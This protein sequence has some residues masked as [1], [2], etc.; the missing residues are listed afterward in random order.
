MQTQIDKDNALALGIVGVASFLIGLGVG[1]VRT[2]Q[3]F[4][5]V[6]ESMKELVDA[7]NEIIIAR[8]MQIEDLIKALEGKV[9]LKTA[10]SEVVE[11]VETVTQTPYEEMVE[12][13]NQRFLHDIA[14]ERAQLKE[15]YVAA[16][17][18]EIARV[19]ENHPANPP[20][21]VST[22]KIIDTGDG[23]VRAWIDEDGLV[24][25]YDE[26]LPTRKEGGIYIISVDEFEEGKQGEEY[27]GGTV[28]FYMG[29]HVVVDDDESVIPGPE[30]LLGPLSAIRPGHG[31]RDASICYIRNEA[32]MTQYEVI[33]EEGSFLAVL[34]AEAAEEDFD[35]DIKH[36]KGMRKYFREED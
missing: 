30:R 32:L 27:T 7:Q 31:S 14:E 29:D 9:E 18:A 19:K 12:S 28:V 11:Q 10:I 26:E 21:P 2:N 16:R 1:I 24:W 5:K 4:K 17:A 22:A 36:S 13:V 34:E 25:D 20:H 33:C 6:L 3:Q 8:G 23:K 15:Q 35:R